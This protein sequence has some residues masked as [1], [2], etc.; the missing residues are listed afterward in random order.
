VLIAETQLHVLYHLSI[1]IHLNS[2]NDVREQ[3]LTHK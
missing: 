3:K 2:D 1:S